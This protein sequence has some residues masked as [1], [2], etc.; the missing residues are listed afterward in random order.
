MKSLSA[1]CVGYRWYGIDSG[2][3]SR[4]GDSNC[5]YASKLKSRKP[6]KSEPQFGRIRK[7][8]L[9][10]DGRVYAIVRCFPTTGL[11][12]SDDMDGNCPDVLSACHLDLCYGR[13]YEEVDSLDLSLELVTASRLLAS[14]LFV[15]SAEE[16]LFAIALQE[17]FSHD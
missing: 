1:V 2:R 15:P 12:L 10:R 3:S 8:V 7:L 13:Q 11:K 16:R 6:G 9:H 5:L 17:R 4:N 14:A